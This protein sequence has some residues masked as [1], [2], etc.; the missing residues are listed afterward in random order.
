MKKVL[1]EHKKLKLCGD[2]MKSGSG[3]DMKWTPSDPRLVVVPCLEKI[4]SN[5]L[6]QLSSTGQIF[7]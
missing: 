6:F 5:I 4:F 3:D 2:D 7:F 1:H